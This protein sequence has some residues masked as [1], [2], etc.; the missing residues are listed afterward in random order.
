MIATSTQNIQSSTP[1][2]VVSSQRGAGAV[3]TSETS[4]AEEKK[5]QQAQKQQDDVVVRQLRARDREVRAH[6]S[7]HVS[8]GGSLVR[9]GPSFTLQKGPDGRS[10][11]IGG[12]VQLD[13]SEAKDPEATVIKSQRVRAAALAPAQPSAQ[14]F[15][16]AG[17]A[18]QMAAR[19]RL[20]I[21][22]ER[23]SEVQATLESAE[24]EE[25][26]GI[27]TDESGSET[28]VNASGNTSN[29]A[30]SSGDTSSGDNASGNNASG[31]DF[32][33]NTSQSNTA[34]SFSATSAGAASSLQSNDA[35]PA[36]IS[37]F[38]ATAQSEPRP[39]QI[40]QFV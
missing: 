35:P 10:Y 3:R 12:E 15:K 27:D 33:G 25:E 9:S 34:T 30:A 39:A 16:V 28:T 23:R 6:E 22:I 17:S 31:G 1:S 7:A 40:N 24:S 18:S 5:A 32:S 26:A 21:A 14:D 29:N 4:K 2:P 13:V 11:A 20:D 36:A 37:A 19:A 38:M 8:A